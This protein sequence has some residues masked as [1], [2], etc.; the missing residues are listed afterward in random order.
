VEELQ[1]LGG[2]GAAEVDDVHDL[3]GLHR[4]EDALVRRG[5]GEAEER[6]E[7]VEV[8]AGGGELG[9]PGRGA[10]QEQR[11]A[12]ARPRPERAARQRLGEGGGD[13]L[14]GVAVGRRERRDVLERGV[15]GVEAARGGGG[16]AVEEEVD[17]AEAA[18]VG[19]EEKGRER[20]RARQRELGG[21]GSGFVGPR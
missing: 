8:P 21:G 10:G 1:P 5:A 18:L 11:P 14:H 17:E 3:L 15:G 7:V 4:L 6:A 19:E 16:G 13:A 12:Q 9:G 20:K 2:V